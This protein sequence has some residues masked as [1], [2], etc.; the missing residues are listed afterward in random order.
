MLLRRIFVTAASLAVT[1][2]CT[3]PTDKRDVNS[4]R[5]DC[6]EQLKRVA[7]AN[8]DGKVRFSLRVPVLDEDGNYVSDRFVGLALPSSRV[9]LQPAQC[10]T[11]KENENSTIET[12]SVSVLV[13][14]G[15]LNSPRTPTD[16][17][18]KGKG[19]W[20]T[21]GARRPG[22]IEKS[23]EEYKRIGHL[24]PRGSEYGLL[25]YQRIFGLKDGK[26][27][28]DAH[29]GSAAYSGRSTMGTYVQIS[30]VDYDIT[31]LVA[32]SMQSEIEPSV[33]LSV[34]LPTANFAS[35][36]EYQDAAEAAYRSVRER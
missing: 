35:W 11:R 21:I 10:E 36:L 29:Y 32:C 13:E 33:G 14:D 6:A 2:A 9:T 18:P 17:A 16:I 34:L 5:Q 15:P 4:V 27:L 30:C 8:A 3:P 31:R 24:S 23:D 26:P 7:S 1:A 12:E 20:L 22:V 19:F 28:P 25:K